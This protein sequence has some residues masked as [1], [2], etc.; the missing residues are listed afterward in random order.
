MAGRALRRT[1]FP[2]GY[3]GRHA[4]RRGG[5]QCREQGE[6]QKNLSHMCPLLANVGNAVN[7]AREIVRYKQGTILHWLHVHRTSLVL[8]IGREPARSK[9]F[10]ASSR[11][12]G[13][14]MSKHDA[15]AKRMLADP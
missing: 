5:S 10:K 8:A 4:A 7:R 14:Q 11:A 12:V 1:G 2:G 6:G 3:V 15:R 13:L 9:D